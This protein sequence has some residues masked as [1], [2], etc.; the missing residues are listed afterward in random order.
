MNKY[1]L[2]KFTINQMK[3]KLY[4]STIQEIKIMKN[5]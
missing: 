1:E 2:L 3:K 5:N 4:L